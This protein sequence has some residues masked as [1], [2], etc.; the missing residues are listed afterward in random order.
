MKKIFI[1][2]GVLL[3][4]A[5]CT[6]GYGDKLAGSWEASNFLVTQIITFNGDGT[7]SI[8]NSFATAAFEY[9]IVDD[10]HMNYR[11]I[12]TGLQSSDQW[13]VREYRLANNNTLIFSGIT[14]IRK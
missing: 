2:F 4:F 6:T 11:E 3:I 12:N 10:T 5:G 8:Q 7:G 14:Y 13:N 9:E 1:F